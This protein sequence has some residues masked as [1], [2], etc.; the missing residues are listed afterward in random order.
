MPSTNTKA[1]RFNSMLTKM[2]GVENSIIAI[3]NK[4]GKE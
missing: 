4:W 3:A 1:I 2:F